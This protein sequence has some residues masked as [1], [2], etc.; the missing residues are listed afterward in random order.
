MN[1]PYGEINGTTLKIRFSSADYSVASVLT[2]LREHLDVIENLGVTFTGVQ[3]DLGHASATAFRPVD[4]VAQFE[5]PQENRQLM[6]KVYK[7]V[8]HGLVLTF[9]PEEVW[10]EAKK[11]YSAYISSQAELIRARTESMKTE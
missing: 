4:I 3:T 2:A 1:M 9:P 11:A 5:A 10:A 8:W 7:L 6:E